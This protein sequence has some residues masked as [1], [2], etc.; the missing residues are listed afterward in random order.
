MWSSPATPCTCRPAVR[1]PM[2]RLLLDN[3][4]PDPARLVVGQA[5]V[6]QYPEEP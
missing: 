5:L 3:R 4:L 1:G 6:I 2:A